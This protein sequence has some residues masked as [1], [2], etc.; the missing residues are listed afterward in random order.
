VEAEDDGE[1]A[2]PEDDDFEADLG[3]ET[4]TDEEIFEIVLWE[5]PALERSATEVY[6][7]PAMIFFAVTSP[8]P[9]SA[10]SS[11]WLAVFRSTGPEDAEEEADDDFLEDDAS[12]A[13]FS[14]SFAGDFSAFSDLSGFEAFSV[15]AG[16]SAFS[17]FSDFADVLPAF[18][19][20]EI[21]W[22]VESET[23]AFERSATDE[24]GRP[25]MIFLAV[26][27]PTPGSASSSCCDAELMSTFFLDAA[28]RE[29]GAR[30]VARTKQTAT[31]ANGKR[32]AS[33]CLNVMACSFS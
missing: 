13:G 11:F 9:G 23:P 5:T 4:V 17:A 1:D 7:R 28:S 19:M 27:S 8:T 20:P 12:A 24:Y 33:E 22:M 30:T 10:S 2:L 6:G 29:A 21:F 18:T 3:D 16:F 32:R 14:F 31:S 26:A 15:F 25:A